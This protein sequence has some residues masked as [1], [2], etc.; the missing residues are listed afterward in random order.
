M[1]SRH[2]S[3]VLGSRIGGCILTSITLTLT[4]CYNR[5]I[6]DEQGFPPLPGATDN[7]S[8]RELDN[9]ANKGEDAPPSAS[10]PRCLR[11]VGGALTENKPQTALLIT[12]YNEDR[13]VYCTGT[14]VSDTT[15]ITAS[16]C[17]SDSATGGVRYIPGAGSI[18]DNDDLDVLYTSGVTPQ[19][20][21]IGAP[22]FTVERFDQ[23]EFQKG[24]NRD[25][26]VLLFPA[27]T[28]PAYVPILEA[29][30]TET[31]ELTM[32]GYGETNSPGEQSSNTGGK[33]DLRRR[34]GTNK[35]VKKPGAADPG[36]AE[37]A[38]II[39]K[40]IY[41]VSGE[42]ITD[43]M[44]DKGKALVGVGDS[45]GPLLV[46]DALVGVAAGGATI[47][48]RVRPFLDN[49]TGLGFYAPLQSIFAKSVIKTAEEGGATIRKVSEVEEAKITLPGQTTPKKDQ[50]RD[51]ELP[52][53]EL[54]TPEPPAPPVEEIPTATKTDSRNGC[55]DD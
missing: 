16:H 30:V 20:V 14:W 3:L 55:G 10:S 23:S 49:A 46:G 51:E 6:Q 54:V 28:A 48:R 7:K 27:G 11:L 19:K 24:M 1:Q 17:L 18:V 8:G 21:F 41:A 44:T 32:V 36:Y 50:E 39:P 37:V 13:Y 29:E 40:E 45:G 52:K 53:E 4:G 43:G 33:L 38:A 42:S 15:M 25:L 31:Q 47:H 35:L 26:A 34:V 12:N 2:T 9:S 5:E 22:E